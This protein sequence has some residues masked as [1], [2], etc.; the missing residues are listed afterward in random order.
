MGY[1]QKML[2][3]ICQH[4]S[5]QHWQSSCQSVNIS[6]NLH[7]FS[8]ISMFE[9]VFRYVCKLSHCRSINIC[10]YLHEGMF[11]S[12]YVFSVCAGVCVCVCVVSPA[13]TSSNLTLPLTVNP[14]QANLAIVTS[15]S[16]SLSLSLYLS[17]SVITIIYFIY[18]TACH[19]CSLPPPVNDALSMPLNANETLAPAR[20]WASRCIFKVRAAD[21]SH[22]PRPYLR[23]MDK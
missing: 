14:E 12:F 23:G 21:V 8:Q 1:A 11:H 4:Q 7:S 18:Q 16:L 5:S 9:Y 15:L 2:Q 13:S 19:A 20:N 3:S 22:L 17:F 10:I 6:L